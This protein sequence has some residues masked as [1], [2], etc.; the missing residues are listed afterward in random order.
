MPEFDFDFHLSSNDPDAVPVTPK[1]MAVIGT[2]VLAIQTLKNDGEVPSTLASI[3]ISVVLSTDDPIGNLKL[4][5]EHTT[6]L[7]PIA[8]ETRNR[9]FAH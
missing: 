7:T 9:S 6:E 4:L 5:N 3:I 2:C 8:L 1:M